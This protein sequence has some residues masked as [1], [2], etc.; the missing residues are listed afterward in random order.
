MA[1]RRKGLTV[2]PPAALSAEDAGVQLAGVSLELDTIEAAAWL[3][4]QIAVGE[5]GFLGMDEKTAPPT[6][7]STVEGN[8]ENLRGSLERWA[9]E[10][11]SRS[12]QEIRKGLRAVHPEE[13]FL[14]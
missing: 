1:A 8:R 4:D 12:V 13:V 7:W 2:V 6:W 3:L 10:S 14:E 11:I 5:L 9:V